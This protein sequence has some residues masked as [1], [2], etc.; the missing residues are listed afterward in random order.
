M[1]GSTVSLGEEWKVKE[2]EEDDDDDD[3]D[4]DSDY[5]NNYLPP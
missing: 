2:V 3:D 1:D 4:D 5:S